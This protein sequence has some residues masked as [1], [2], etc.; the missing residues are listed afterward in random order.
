MDDKRKRLLELVKESALSIGEITLS[1]GKKSS[2]YIDCRRITLDPEGAYLVA[3]ILLD[4]FHGKGIDAV[5]GLTLGADPILG[6]LAAV[7]FLEGNPI[8]TFIVRKTSKKHGTRNAIEGRLKEGS[9]VAVVDDVATTGN[10]LMQVIDT[11]EKMDCEVRK[12]V[13]IV[14][15]EE[16]AKKTMARRGYRMESVFSRR[17]LGV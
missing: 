9:R 6:A 15:R 1:S 13:V 7:S 10:S 12:V 5:G 16:G 2:Y 14:D 8:P 17:E 4:M 11:V 3:K